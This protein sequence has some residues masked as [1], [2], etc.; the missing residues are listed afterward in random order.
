MP[1]AALSPAR[2]FLLACATGLLAACG[3]SPAIKPAELVK[4]TP[5][6]TATVAWRA[7]VGDAGAYIFTPA[8]YR[9]AVYAASAKG[10]VAR[11]DAANG[12]QAWRVETKRPLSGGV[13]ADADLVLVGTLKGEVVALDLEGKAVWSAQVSS[14]VLSAPRVAEGV[15]VVRSGD[16]RIVGLDA[17]DGSRRWEYASS[18]PPLLLRRDA[19]VTLARGAAFAGL[20]N[21]RLVA[22]ALATGVVAWEGVVAQSKGANELERMVDVAAAPL[23]D[24]EQACAV[25]FQGRV[26]CFEPAKGTLLWGR[27]ASSAVALASDPGTLYL[28]DERGT[29]M[30]LDRDSGATYW[31]TDKLYGRQVSAP[32]V[33][34]QFVAVGD[35]QGYVHFLNRND[36]SFAARVATD[37]SPILA[38]P[39]RVGSNVLVQTRK[40]GLFAI[41]L[42]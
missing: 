24:E 35:Y 30:A 36:G 25:A 31:K 23:V 9:G 6:A 1:A 34:G 4:F 26:A 21:G 40:G 16:G 39:Q 15:A 27:D 41:A 20:H 5:T 8:L 2:A 33:A 14:E 10:A 18:M 29:V 22:L 3:G 12:K 7:N 42:K 37:G 28:S 32:V 11:F 17:K 38:R 13:G 19:G